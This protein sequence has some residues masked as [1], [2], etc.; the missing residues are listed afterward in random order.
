MTVQSEAQ[1]S[2]AIKSRGVGKG[3]RGAVRST[4][5]LRRG[6]RAGLAGAGIGSVGQMLAVGSGQGPRGC[7][8]SLEPFDFL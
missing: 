3:N 4:D 8:K 6:G 2:A 7:R 5:A 1:E